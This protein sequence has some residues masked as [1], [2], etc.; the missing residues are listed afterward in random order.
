[1]NS[2]D[3]PDPNGY[4]IFAGQCNPDELCVDTFFPNGLHST[5]FCITQAD[6][7]PYIQVEYD[8]K[9][10]AT[11]AAELA[12]LG[13]FLSDDADTQYSVEAVV[14]SANTQESLSTSNLKI[15]AQKSTIVHDAPLWQTL[16]GG[17]NRCSGCGSVGLSVLPNGTQ[18]FLLDVSLAAGVTAGKIWLTAWKPEL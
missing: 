11:L 1:M 8:K 9:V 4:N 6:F 7:I 15:Q 18:R 16:A 17:M 10:E 5:A 2:G 13:F 12:E 3:E 14:T